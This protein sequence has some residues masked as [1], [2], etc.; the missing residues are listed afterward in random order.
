[1]TAKPKV[2]T[3]IPARLASTRFPGK[4]LASIQG[5]P[6]IE[7]VYRRCRK[8]PFVDSVFVATDSSEIEKAVEAFGGKAL[9][10]S[11][12]HRSGTDRLAEAASILGLE[13]SDIVLNVQGDQPA[14]DPS[15]P[16]LIAQSLLSDRN[17]N[18]ATL[19]VPLTDKNEI[20]DPNHVKVVFDDQGYALYFSRAPIPWPRDGQAGLFYKHIGLYGYTVEF[21]NKFVLWPVGVLEDLEKLEQLRVL[22]RGFKIKVLLAQGLSPEVDVPE[23]ISKVEIALKASKS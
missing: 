6:M 4:P 3:I 11:A 21:L 2:I 20:N 5:R 16:S 23:D 19:A 10:T 18:M 1:M 15:H 17:L 12:A 22:E 14:L 8:I 13:G 7:H 9:M